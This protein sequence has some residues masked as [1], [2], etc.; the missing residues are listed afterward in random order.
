MFLDTIKKQK[1]DPLFSVN[2]VLESVITKRIDDQNSIEAIK[3]FDSNRL[4]FDP[5]HALYTSTS[6]T[7]LKTPAVNVIFNGADY[8]E[9]FNAVFSTYDTTFRSIFG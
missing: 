8:D 6:A 7:P 2:S 9:E 4:F 1:E 3:F 5:A